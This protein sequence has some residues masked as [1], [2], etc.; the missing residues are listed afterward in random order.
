VE[1]TRLLGCAMTA[2]FAAVLLRRMQPGMGLA[3]ALAG[4]TAVLLLAL[5]ALSRLLEELGALARA[6]G[7]RDDFVVQ[8]LKIVGISLLV[9]FAAQTCRDAGEEGLAMKTELAGRALLL[10]QALP[11]LQVLLHQVLSLAG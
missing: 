11:S 5:P 6:G 4:G 1:V 9:E 2:L 3:A 7:V 8:L 10:L